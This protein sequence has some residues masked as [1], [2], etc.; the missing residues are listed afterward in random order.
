M[1]STT[2]FYMSLQSLYQAKAKQDQEE[3]THLLEEVIAERNVFKQSIT[4]D[5]IKRYC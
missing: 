1:T 2:D 3:F 5:E 4:E